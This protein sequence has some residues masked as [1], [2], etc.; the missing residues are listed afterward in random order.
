MTLCARQFVLLSSARP[1][2]PAAHGWTG[3]PLDWALGKDEL[4]RPFVLNLTKEL[5]AWSAASG[6][7]PPD[8]RIW[9][10]GAGAASTLS[11]EARFFDAVS[12]GET[13][14]VRAGD[15][16]V[17]SSDS[18]WAPM[19]RD[20]VDVDNYPWSCCVLFSAIGGRAWWMGRRM[21]KPADCCARWR[22]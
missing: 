7:S 14:T 13:D 4:N 1:S 22:R 15:G 2:L 5:G 16:K 10:T 11:F 21:R 20:Q 18:C 17:C 12:G 9:S 19:F 8:A 6:H 3:G